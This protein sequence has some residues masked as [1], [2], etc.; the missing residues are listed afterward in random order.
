MKNKLITKIHNARTK[1]RLN[2]QANSHRFNT[3][4]YSSIDILNFPLIVVLSRVKILLLRQEGGE[5]K[6]RKRNRT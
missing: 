4:L 1:E 3:S 2:F 5:R 6:E